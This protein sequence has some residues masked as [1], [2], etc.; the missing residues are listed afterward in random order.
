MSLAINESKQAQWWGHMA[1]VNPK[2]FLLIQ[3]CHPYAGNLNSEMSGDS[4]NAFLRCRGSVVQM[5]CAQMIMSCRSDLSN[6]RTELMPLSLILCLFGNRG[7][8]QPDDLLP[9]LWRQIQTV[10]QYHTQRG[11]LATVLES[12]PC[13]RKKHLSTP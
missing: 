5:R 3:K 11:I 6:C 2:S 13:L 7:C 10:L 8:A 1:L 12:S 9:L 4:R